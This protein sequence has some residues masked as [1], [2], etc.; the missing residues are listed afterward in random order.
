[1]RLVVMLLCGLAGLAH[2]GKPVA[3]GPLKAY[4]GPEG[5]VVAL[6][7]VNDSKDVLVY[8]RKI[9]G[10]DGTTLLYTNEDLGE[11]RRQIYVTKKRGSKTYRSIMLTDYSPGRWLFINPVKTSE[12]FKIRYSESTTQS[13]KP[14]EVINAYK[15]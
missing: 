3:S 11:D 14:D 7:P 6:V 12:H 8:F 10:L 2:A 9:S 13:I 1:M 15:P 4:V 5:E